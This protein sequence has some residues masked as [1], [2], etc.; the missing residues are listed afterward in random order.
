MAAWGV[1]VST[2]AASAIAREFIVSGCIV[3]IPAGM[4][5]DSTKPFG[6]AVNRKGWCMGKPARKMTVTQ[7][8]AAGHE[9][10]DSAKGFA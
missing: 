4:G 1:A 2:A 5:L 9:T 10:A 8:N 6:E 7:K 3:R